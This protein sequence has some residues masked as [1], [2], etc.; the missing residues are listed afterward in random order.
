MKCI[1][2]GILMVL[3]LL[4]FFTSLGSAVASSDNDLHNFSSVIS[5]DSD[6]SLNSPEDMESSII[7]NDLLV[8]NEDSPMSGDNSVDFTAENA[9]MSQDSKNSLSGNALGLA[10][11]S[12]VISNDVIVTKS[13]GSSQLSSPQTI[14]IKDASCYDGSINEYIQN[15]IDDAAAGSTIQF[16]GSSYENIYLKISKPLNIISKSG[17]RISNVF[18]IPVFTILPG[19]SGTNIS[20]FT[21][22]LAGSFV[23]ARDVSR[24]GISG[25]KIS[26]KRNAIVLNEVYDSFIKNNLFSSF[27][28]A[29]DISNSGGIAIS[30]NNIS[31]SNANNIGINIKEISSKKG[32]TIT[33]NN[34]TASDR[35][36]DGTGIY[37]GKN[38]CNILVKGN[39]IRQWYTAINFPSSVNNVTIINN[40]ISDNGDGV[41]IN[42]YINDFTFNK[43]LVTGNGRNG[44]LFDYDFMAVKGNFNL[45]NN[46]FSYNGGMDLKN[47][48]DQAVSIGKNFAKRRCTRVGMKYGF[49]IRSRQS[50]SKYY[51]SVVDRYGNAVS[52]LP[53]FSAILTVNG[54]QYTVNFIDSV[55]F[56]D[57][58]SGSG[59][60]DGSA[61]SLNI[62]EDNRDFSKWGQFDQVDSFEMD[63]YEDFYNQLL[64]SIM[65]TAKS[66]DN[67]DDDY[68]N[69]SGSSSSSGSGSGDSGVSS[70]ANSINSN[71]L[72][73]GSSG[74]SISSASA[75]SSPSQSSSAPESTSA[76]T[77]SVDEETF[78]VLGVGGLVFLFILVIGLYYRED[79]KDMM[80]E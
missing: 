31:P 47:Q 43:N 53:N 64:N 74:A 62:G 51:F 54:R 63:Y 30:K 77:L 55:A 15:L 9:E 32:I 79:I 25:N 44:V 69:E 10:D 50:G 58:G 36:K 22:N 59:G 65:G 19:G 20:G 57:I 3:I 29:I 4:I 41:I 5:S 27:K 42:G 39:T 24:I 21:V 34:I 75:S 38:A 67:R 11:D 56:I 14:V 7:N 18:D 66:N 60:K 78:R 26:T 17:T 40:T 2:K 33:D 35:R 52:G 61:S 1:R 28:I 68:E 80:E 76:K 72:M 12:S 70:G 37:F 49:N 13:Q 6:I 8:S 23:D 71:G 45:E 48:G 73:S 16:T 46:F